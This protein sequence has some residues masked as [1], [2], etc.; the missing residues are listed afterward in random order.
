MG[1]RRDR[2]INYSLRPA[3]NI[4]RK[5]MAEAFGRLAAICPLAQF[6][7]VGFGSEFFND[8]A[9]FHQLLGIHDMTS[10]ER[11]EARRT[12]CAFNRP[13]KCVKL[14][15]GDSRVVLPTLPWTKRAIVWLDYTDAL[16]KAI[17]EDAALLVSQVRSGSVL[18][19]TV[20]AHPAG[21]EQGERLAP[22]GGAGKLPDRRLS[23]LKE[24]VG[25]NR[26]R[27]ELKGSELATWGLAA[28]SYSILREEIERA[29]SGR[30]GAAKPNDQLAF[31]QF[32]HFRYRDGQRM[33]TLG[34]IVVSEADSR[35]LGK[36]PFKG[37]RFIRDGAEPA[38]IAPPTLTGREVRHLN[39][40]LP[41]HGGKLRGPAWLTSG[42]YERYR[43]IYR[44]YPIFAE[45][46]L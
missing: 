21:D 44:Y 42:E 25:D 28:E 23:Q 20:N 16:N 7:Y 2:I 19:W 36:N 22:N 43:E 14:V 13:Y 38:T 33:L 27:A 1:N 11:D 41:K 40:L 9:L 31:R 15:H 30:N 18:V 24:R 6:R 8:F 35:K 4:E 46:E 37:L 26:V 29:L 12:R 3:K 10:I 34:G 5:M 39:R 17:L 32:L 45:S